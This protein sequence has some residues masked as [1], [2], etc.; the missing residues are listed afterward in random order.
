MA[1]VCEL[2]LAVYRVQIQKEVISDLKRENQFLSN[3]IRESIMIVLS[4][5]IC[6]PVIKLDF[7][8]HVTMES[9]S[10]FEPR[11]AHGAQLKGQC[12]E[13]FCFWFFS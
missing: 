6:Q 13:I 9:L 2:S 11:C 1:G 8:A 4:R 10:E 7:T 3:E 5:E 12:H